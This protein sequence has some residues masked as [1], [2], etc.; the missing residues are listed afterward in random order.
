M[1]VYSARKFIGT[2]DGAYTVGKDAG[3]FVD[4]YERDHSSD[5]SLFL[6]LRVEY[7]CEGKAYEARR[8]NEER[9]NRSDV[10]RMSALTHRILG[11][12]DYEFIQRKRQEN[13]RT[14]CFLLNGYN[15]LSVESYI[16]ADSVPMVY[17]C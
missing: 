8:A 13:F 14:A 6:L 2:P 9:L 12:A 1:N 11:A 17:P 5:T 16:S 4:E 7:G 3:C 10:M 15:E